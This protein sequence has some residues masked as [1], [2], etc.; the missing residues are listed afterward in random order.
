MADQTMVKSA[1]S[2][3]ARLAATAFSMRARYWSS[4]TDTAFQKNSNSLVNKMNSF[5]DLKK[6]LYSSMQ[7]LSLG[8]VWRELVVFS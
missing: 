8:I 4:P 7:L 5:Q 3:P 6:G 2:C 1:L